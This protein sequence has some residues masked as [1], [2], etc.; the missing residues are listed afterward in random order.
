MSIVKGYYDNIKPVYNHNHDCDDETISG[1]H[2]VWFRGFGA[3]ETSYQRWK[4]VTI[5]DPP[6]SWNVFASGHLRIGCMRNTSGT[7]VN[8][9]NDPV[10]IDILKRDNDN[11]GWIAGPAEKITEGPNPTG[12]RWI[13]AQYDAGIA[14]SAIEPCNNREGLR[15][16]PIRFWAQEVPGVGSEANFV[17]FWNNTVARS[18]G[19][20]T[21]STVLQAYTFLSSSVASPVSVWT[22]YPFSQY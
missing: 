6:A 7:G 1:S 8:A 16:T 10:N 15:L 13:I 17:Q 3:H 14:G 9:Y 4:N 5:S 22:N 11:L 12:E 2:I 19:V 18:S 20:A 21:I